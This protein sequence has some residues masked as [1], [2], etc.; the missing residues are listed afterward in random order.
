[1]FTQINEEMVKERF[2]LNIVERTHGAST[3][4]IMFKLYLDYKT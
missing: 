3:V 1:M 4:M 2:Y